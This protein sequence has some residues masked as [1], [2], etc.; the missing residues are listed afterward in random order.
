MKFILSGSISTLLTKKSDVIILLSQKSNILI[1][2]AKPID[3]A[4]IRIKIF[5]HLY[6]LKVHGMSLDQ[7][8]GPGNMELLRKEVKFSISILLKTIS[9]WLINKNRLKK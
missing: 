7:Y 1:Q 9:R 2:V 6:W 3:N 4:V 5:E 8:L